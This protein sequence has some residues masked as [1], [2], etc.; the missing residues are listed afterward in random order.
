MFFDCDNDGDL[1]LYVAN[2]LDF[3]PA[4]NRVCG[5]TITPKRRRKELLKIPFALRTY[6]SPRRYNGVPDVLYRNDGA[7]FVDAT[8]Q[9]G[10]FNRFGKG[11]GALASDFD[12]DGDMDLYV[13]ND[14]VRQCTLPQ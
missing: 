9:A 7:T 8:E 1:D 4:N 13:A 3:Y 14:G 11:L 10:V 12:A 5:G 6:C 2:Y